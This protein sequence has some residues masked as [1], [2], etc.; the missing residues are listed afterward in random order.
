M[1]TYTLNNNKNNKRYDTVRGDFVS[2]RGEW[3][4]WNFWMTKG[5][6]DR[7]EEAARQTERSQ[8]SIVREALDMQLITILQNSEKMVAASE[9]SIRQR[10]ERVDLRPAKDTHLTGMKPAQAWDTILKEK[11]VYAGRL[12]IKDFD[13]WIARLEKNKRSIDPENPEYERVM[14][15]YDI[16]IAELDEEREPYVGGV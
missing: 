1:C 4:R 6:K 16:Y 5:Q 13:A 3:F 7:L 10:K 14:E 11:R 8:A 12:T 15:K 9:L 2:N